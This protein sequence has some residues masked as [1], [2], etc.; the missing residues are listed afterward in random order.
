[1]SEQSPVHV[2]GLQASD[3]FT[4]I[5]AKS[6]DMPQA[7]KDT[8]YKKGNGIFQIDIVHNGKT[9]SW[10]LDLKN[11]ANTFVTLGDA[12][13][14][15][16][17]ADVIMAM[18]DEVFMDLATGKINGQKAFLS[19]KLK[20]KGN[21]MLAPKLEAVLKSAQDEVPGAKL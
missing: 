8:Y 10:T 9:H 18:K 7:E 11:K 6:L 13:S 20:L 21:M 1:M 19:G 3:L 16:K 2:E 12:K 17:K 14:Q 4:L 5:Y 15:G